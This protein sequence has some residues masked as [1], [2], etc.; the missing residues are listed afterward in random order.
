MADHMG[1]G[2]TLQTLAL[3]YTLL[4]F[5]QKTL[6]K[7]KFRRAIVVCP[8]TLVHNWRVECKKWLG[9][10]ISPLVALGDGRQVRD[11]C[12]K[13]AHDQY[14]LLIVSYESFYTNINVLD[15]CCDIVV[16]DEG[17]RLK[18]PKSRLF[19]AIAKFSC[20]GRILLTG[21]PIQNSIE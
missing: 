8:L 16:F 20:R 1:L 4:S 13:F 18:N 11:E 7:K 19:K 6:G 15:G 2:K 5:K 21:T 3:L 9:E 12:Q 17:H 14:R 10:R